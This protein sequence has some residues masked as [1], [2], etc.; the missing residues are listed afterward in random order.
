MNEARILN[1]NELALEL[2]NLFTDSFSK[3]FTL[4]EAINDFA[5]KLRIFNNLKTT[6]ISNTLLDYNKKRN[7]LLDFNF[8][9]VQPL[10]SPMGK[11]SKRLYSSLANDY[12]ITC[13][14]RLKSFMSFFKKVLLYVEN[15]RSIIFIP[16]TIGQRYI[17]TGKTEQEEISCCYEITKKILDFLLLEERAQMM[18]TS[19]S[20]NVSKNI[21]EGI[22]LPTSEDIAQLSEIHDYNSSLIKD[23]IMNPKQNGYQN[24][25]FTVFLTSLMLPLELQIRGSSMHIRA[26]TSEAIQHELYKSSKYDSDIINTFLNNI[27]WGDIKILGYS[28]N[29]PDKIGFLEPYN[30]IQFNNF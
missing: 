6:S 9:D 30:F 22:L 21:P 23:Y 3:Y 2:A 5:I 26:E 20:R 17:V 13:E 10:K 27:Q 29:I 18:E 12:N 14:S 4:S 7:G 16:D 25:Q 1:N 19:P 15:N 8:K 28:S 24:L 11:M